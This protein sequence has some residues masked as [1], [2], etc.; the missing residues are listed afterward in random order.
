MWLTQKPVKAKVKKSLKKVKEKDM[1]NIAEATTKRKTKTQVVVD[2]TAIAST[3]S[4]ELW[5]KKDIKFDNP[6]MDVR[7]H[8]L[9]YTGTPARKL[10]FNTYNGTLGKSSKVLPIEAFLAD[11]TNA[12]QKKVWYNVA[13]IDKARLQLQKDGYVLQ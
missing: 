12:D 6:K 5:T 7:A 3:K 1:E 2:L 11:K 8:V 9:L 13:D 4:C 10:C